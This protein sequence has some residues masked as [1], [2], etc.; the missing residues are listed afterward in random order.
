MGLETP[1]GRETR[2]LTSIGWVT[3]MVLTRSSSEQRNLLRQVDWQTY[4]TLVEQTDRAG[5]RI[6]YDQGLMEL[7]TPSMPHESYGSL[8]GRL[9]ER[10]TELRDIE[11]RSVASTT[12]RRGDLK[13][14]FEA[15]ESYY[16]QHASQLQGV[17]E[18]ELTI[19]PPPDLVIEVELSR[20]AID[21]LALFAAMKVPEVWRYDEVKLWAGVR[22]GNRYDGVTQ[23]AALPG[24]PLDLADQ[25]L[26][27]RFD[28]NETKLVREFVLAI[29]RDE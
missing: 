13:R 1:M 3:E 25:I 19:H 7:M 17:R 15:D 20:S 12:F 29:Q 10:Y 21:K 5:C 6:T 16:I 14:G 24:F 8:L 9:I 26:S 22:N 18:V 28:E 2:T 23:S 11:I 4:L 27:R